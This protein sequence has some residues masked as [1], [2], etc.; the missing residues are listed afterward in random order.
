[1]EHVIIA[2]RSLPY[3]VL[4][5]ELLFVP[6]QMKNH[7]GQSRRTYSR[8]RSS[9]VIA[10]NS[11][12]AYVDATLNVFTEFDSDVSFAS[13]RLDMTVKSPKALVMVR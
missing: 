12:M 3:E 11:M 10:K 4:F 5:F 1:V 6:Q 7:L 13:R 8:M 2:V 9:S